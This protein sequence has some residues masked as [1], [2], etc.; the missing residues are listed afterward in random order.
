MTHEVL[1][2]DNKSKKTN[3][4]PMRCSIKVLLKGTFAKI[5]PLANN[6][7]VSF[8]LSINESQRLVEIH[9]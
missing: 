1:K 5:R 2:K 8:E 6:Q 9:K 7:N 3:I 4:M